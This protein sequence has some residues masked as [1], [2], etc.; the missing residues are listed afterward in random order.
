MLLTALPVKMFG[1]K[2]NGRDVNVGYQLS[3]VF[4][5]C[6]LSLV[7]IGTAYVFPS[8]FPGR[9]EADA[10]MR[11]GAITAFLSLWATYR[12]DHIV[13]P[14]HDYYAETL[15]SNYLPITRDLKVVVARLYIL[16]FFLLPLE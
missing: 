13:M 6:V 12:L 14:Y 4:Y 10:F 1:W 9:S 7:A 2:F 5:L 16:C 15:G 3:L 8:C 11:A